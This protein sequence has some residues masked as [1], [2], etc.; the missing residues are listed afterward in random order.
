MPTAIIADDEPHMR[1]MLREQ[2]DLLWPDLEIV[3]EP[4][5]GPSALMQ[6]ESLRPDIAFL[7]IRMPGLTGL[8]VARSI[9]VPCRIVFVTAYESHA[10]EAFEANAVD[11]LLKPMDTARLAKVVTRLRKPLD[12]ASGLSAHQLM[13]A[14]ARLGV[15]APAATSA[16]PVSARLEWLQVAAGQRVHLVHVDD[17]HYFESDTKY[18]RVV[19][20]QVEGLIRL[21]L[22]ELLAQLDG[23]IYV[24]V[25]RGAVVNRRCIAAVHKHDDAMEIELRGRDERIRV[26]TANHHLFKA[27]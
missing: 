20:N 4:G 2:L 14:L 21:S 7:D 18:T 12:A 15:T 6:I 24:Q 9:S 19:S 8:Q 27:M 16:A 10:I 22:K 13:E 17:V 25:H 1:E 23:T 26:S 3:A 11:Y 5:D